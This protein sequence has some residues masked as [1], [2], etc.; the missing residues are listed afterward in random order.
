LAAVGPSITGDRRVHLNAEVQ[1][2]L[3]R[4]VTAT[5]VTRRVG[6][7]TVTSVQN[8]SE[9][10]PCMRW[11]GL[12]QRRCSDRPITRLAGVAPPTTDLDDSPE[13][14]GHPAPPRSEVPSGYASSVGGEAISTG[15][16]ACAQGV[17]GN[18]FDAI[19]IINMMSTE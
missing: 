16:V 5:V 11:R 13:I 3:A 15:K 17:P 9:A 10:P 6:E 12:Y 8:R 19:S 1:L 7:V 4:A 18:Y 2:H 14:A